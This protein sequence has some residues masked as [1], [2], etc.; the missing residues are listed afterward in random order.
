MPCGSAATASA[1]ARREIAIIGNKR[2]LVAAIH[3]A[4]IRHAAE[5]HVRIRGEVFVDLKRDAVAR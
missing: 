4:G 1:R 3:R 2:G 5:H